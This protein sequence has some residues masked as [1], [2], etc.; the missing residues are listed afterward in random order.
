MAKQLKN[1]EIF[2][3]GNWKGSKEINVTS[4]DLDD[5][6]ASFEQLSLPTEGY[7][8]MLKLGHQDQQKYFGQAKGAPALGFVERIWREGDK[9]LA[10][11][12]NVPDALL[13][14]VEQRRY[15]Q[16]SIE[17]YASVEHAGQT[18][19]NVL[20]AVALLGAELPAVKGLKEL[21]LSLFTDVSAPWCGTESLVTSNK[22]Q[23]AVFSQ[24]QVD[25]LIASATAK[26]LDAAKIKFDADHSAALT[27][28]G[29][30]VTA[31]EAATVAAKA[32]AKAAQ[33]ALFD[34][35]ADVDS[36]RIVSLVDAA[37]AAGKILPK[38]KDEM[39]ALGQ[40]MTNKVKLGDKEVAGS[41]A[42][43][44][45]LGNMTKAINLSAV[46]K[47]TPV[48]EGEDANPATEVDVQTRT[49][50]AADPTGKLGYAEARKIVLNADPDLKQRYANMAAG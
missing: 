33:K 17:F 18:F 27:A 30:K 8:P 39:I 13:A 40:S 14:L 24:E 22:E 21:A 38:A 28:A 16:V 43:E 20:T 47:A 10:D 1:V 45:L 46:S 29:A 2:S 12:G 25:A 23:T 31:A 9:L 19:K 36:K 11:F 6:I 32:E 50:M 3:V 42:F 37:I 34:F 15:N 4:Q 5:M 35:E 49:R 26:A 41:E 7:K 44:R 48:K